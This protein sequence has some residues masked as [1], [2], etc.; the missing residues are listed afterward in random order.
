MGDEQ[1]LRER[2]AA[3]ETAALLEAWTHEERL[4][5]AEALLADALAGRGLSEDVLQ[6]LKRRRGSADAPAR[7]DDGAGWGGALFIWAAA[8]ML[9]MALSAVVGALV[10]REAGLMAALAVMLVPVESAGRGL[11]RQWRR[12]RDAVR[13]LAL[14]YRGASLALFALLLVGTLVGMSLGRMDGWT[15]GRMDASAAAGAD[16]VSDATTTIAG[17]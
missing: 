2:L 16:Q 12:P 13:T 14:L 6:Q 1:A 7:P 8:G 3:M 11:W 5:W 9:A 15:D 4:P 10:D 17:V